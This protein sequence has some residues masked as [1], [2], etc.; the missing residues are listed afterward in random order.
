MT[1]W[2]IERCMYVTPVRL[3]A[4]VVETSGTNNSIFRNTLTRTIDDQT[5]RNKESFVSYTYSE[6]NSSFLYAV[7]R[8]QANLL[9]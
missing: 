8:N 4:Q 5:I 9:D 7:H 3:T 6:T 2:R 1:E